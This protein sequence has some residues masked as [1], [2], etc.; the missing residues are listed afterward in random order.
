M[1]FVSL[2]VFSLLIGTGLAAPG[3]ALFS[4]FSNVSGFVLLANYTDLQVLYARTMELE[5][6]ILLATW[7]NYC[8]SYSHA[9]F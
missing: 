8:K 2:P 5:G 4:T 1:H 9:N 6:G 7:E 3:L